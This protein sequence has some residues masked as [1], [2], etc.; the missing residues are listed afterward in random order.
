M[1]SCMRPHVAV[2]LATTVAPALAFA[3]TG[4]DI[5]DAASS[6]SRLDEQIIALLKSAEAA[7]LSKCGCE[8]AV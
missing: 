7:R 2:T 5:M 1:V 8:G 4:R 3:L 6:D